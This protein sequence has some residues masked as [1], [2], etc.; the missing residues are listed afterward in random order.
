MMLA[1][2]IVV[3]ISM[4]LALSLSMTAQTT[5]QTNDLY[6]YEQSTLMSKSA[7]EY[8]LL[9]ISQNPP[10]SI[11]HLNFTQDNIYKIDIRMKYVYTAPSPCANADD[12]YFNIATPE[13]SGI[14]LM[15]IAVT[16]NDKSVVSEPIRFFRRS[17]QKL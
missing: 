10:C 12:I 9:K 11:T 17:V 2:G 3:A 15:D 7:A 16:I 13:S 14:V 1:L 8:A 4:I 5:K 6:L